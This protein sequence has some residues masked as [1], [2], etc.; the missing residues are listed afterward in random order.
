MAYDNEMF[1]EFDDYL[2]AYGFDN[3]LD[4]VNDDLWDEI[5]DDFEEEEEEEE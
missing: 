4:M 5:G 3:E 1:D 2:A